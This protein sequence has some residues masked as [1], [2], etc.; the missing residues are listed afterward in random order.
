M[1]V[2]EDRAHH[3]A[4]VGMLEVLAYTIHRV[5]SEVHHVNLIIFRDRSPFS[6]IFNILLLK[7]TLN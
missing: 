3:P 5:S 7:L 4:V 2:V 6:T 1:E